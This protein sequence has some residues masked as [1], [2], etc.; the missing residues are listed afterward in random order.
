M[1]EEKSQT[2]IRDGRIGPFGPFVLERRIA[3]GGC[4]EVFL[5][6][7]RQGQKPA[8]ELVI[9]RLA[10]PRGK[11]HDFDV[12]SREAE[13]HRAV[14]H[15]NVV[16]VFGA[17]MVGDEPY[18]AMEYVPGVDLHRLLRLAGQ[19]VRTGLGLEA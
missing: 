4:A 6:R 19:D 1:P 11:Q 3:I 18:L 15:G 12:L 2:A 13:L 7:P 5:A 9:K 10:R 8:P 14:R 17:G 16:T